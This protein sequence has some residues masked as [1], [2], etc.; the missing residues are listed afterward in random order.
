MRKYKQTR[1][2]R[3]KIRYQLLIDNGYT[4]KEARKYRYRGDI[5]TRGLRVNTEGKVVK[6]TNYKLISK[7]VRIDETINRLRKVPNP[8]VFTQ[9]GFLAHNSIKSNQGLKDEYAKIVNT[10]RRR[11]HLSN[12]QAWYFANFMMT[13]GYSYERTRRELLTKAD[14]E[15]YRQQRQTSK[16]KRGKS[17]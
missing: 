14:F 17:K 10:I 5:D 4:P 13:S 12:D 8:T 7:S 6:G 16:P 3:A 9:H 1:N 15:I 2:E 11:D